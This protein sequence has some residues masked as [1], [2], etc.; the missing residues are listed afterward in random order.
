MSDDL[1]PDGDPFGGIPFLGE[2]MRMLQGQ[3]TGGVDGARQLARSIAT[4][5][6]SEPNIDPAD[7]IAV[8]ELVRVAELHVQNATDLPVTRHGALRVSVTN[9][10]QWADETIDHYLSLIHI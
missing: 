4:E 5:G 2:L 6:A 8:E 9:R 1:P 3:A 7:R 10:A